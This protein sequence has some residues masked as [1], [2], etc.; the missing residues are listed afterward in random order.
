MNCYI[1]K[2]EFTII[3]DGQMLCSE[4]CIKLAVLFCKQRAK[5]SKWIDR[6]NTIY[7]LNIELINKLHENITIYQGHWLFG[8]GK[9]YGAVHIRGFSYTAHRLSLSVYLK[10]DYDDTNWWAC[11][12]CPY[13]RC[14]NPTHLY[15]GSPKS[16]NLDRSKKWTFV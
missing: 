1:C 11:H 4:R 12:L 9:G 6:H 13:K 8:N 10:L 7:K 5:P 14:I 2:K 15:E 3:R 16:N